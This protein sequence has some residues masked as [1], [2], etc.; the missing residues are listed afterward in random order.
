[1][2]APLRDFPQEKFEFPVPAKA[3]RGGA[4]SILKPRKD[5]FCV[6]P[7]LPLLFFLLQHTF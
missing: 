2:R 5:I 1:M 4:D 6:A 7:V 3:V